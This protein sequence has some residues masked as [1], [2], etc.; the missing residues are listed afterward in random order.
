MYGALTLRVYIVWCLIKHVYHF[1]LIVCFLVP[2]RNQ[3]PCPTNGPVP[4]AFLS[5]LAPIRHSPMRAA[6]P[7][8]LIW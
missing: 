1:A 7:A 4:S 5:D 8:S 3:E 2:S 6:C